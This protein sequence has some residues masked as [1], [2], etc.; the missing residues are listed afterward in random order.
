MDQPRCW[1]KRV[2][3]PAPYSSGRRTTSPRATAGSRVGFRHLRPGFRVLPLRLLRHGAGS[4]ITSRVRRTCQP[5]LGLTGVRR[6][7]RSHSSAGH[8]ARWATSAVPRWL[9]PAPGCPVGGPHLL[10]PR[11]VARG[12][13][14]PFGFPLHTSPPK[15]PGGRTWGLGEPRV[16]RVAVRRP[17]FNGHPHKLSPRYVGGRRAY[18]SAAPSSDCAH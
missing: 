7:T 1:P 14:R 10:A 18:S 2:R 8:A 4:N 13:S 12:G 11:V 16:A 6:L 5:A 15:P 17:D 3:F 9:R